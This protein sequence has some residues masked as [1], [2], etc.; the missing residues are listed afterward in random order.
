[1]S[2]KINLRY[3]R[4]WLAFKS[5]SL[6]CNAWKQSYFVFHMDAVAFKS[7]SQKRLAFKSK[8]L[9]LKSGIKFEVEF[10]H[11]SFINDVLEK[12]CFKLY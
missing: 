1:M 3:L 2:F 12:N 7:K 8:S 11:P 10:S 6:A 5:D 9:N 4:K